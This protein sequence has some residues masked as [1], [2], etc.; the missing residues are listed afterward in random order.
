MW[1]LCG[2]LWLGVTA[3]VIALDWFSKAWVLSHL[4]LGEPLALT[5]FMNFTLAYNEGAAFSFLH[6]ASGWQNIFFCTLAFVASI[7]ILVWLF[8]HPG[9]QFAWPNFALSLIMGG[10]LGNVY[11]RLTYGYVIDFFDF[12]WQGW[13]FAIFNIADSAIFVGAVLMMWYW[14]R[15][16][17]QTA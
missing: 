2:L 5:S 16:A 14:T 11:D 17:K 1:R 8:N 4:Q 15:S 7:A 6:N 3:M 9:R 10:A 12:H 13:H